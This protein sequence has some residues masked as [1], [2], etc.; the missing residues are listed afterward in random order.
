[1]E[2]PFWGPFPELLHRTIPVSSDLFLFASLEASRWKRP[3][4]HLCV[5]TGLMASL[6]TK[7]IENMNGTQQE[8]SLS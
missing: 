2:L 5:L 7:W 8:H 1:M 3:A 6:V 4:F